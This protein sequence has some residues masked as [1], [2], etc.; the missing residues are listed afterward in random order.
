MTWPAHWS[1]GRVPS[2]VSDVADPGT[3]APWECRLG[4]YRTNPSVEPDMNRWET[5]LEVRLDN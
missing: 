4:I 2:L 3:R 5:A 1:N